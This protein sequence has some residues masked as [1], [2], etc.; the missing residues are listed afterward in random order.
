MP[1]PEERCEQTSSVY[2]E[3]QAIIDAYEGEDDL[4]YTLTRAPKA[5]VK[6]RHLGDR[7]PRPCWIYIPR[8]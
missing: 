6:I 5:C 2:D 3:V 7:K 8:R 4:D 1:R